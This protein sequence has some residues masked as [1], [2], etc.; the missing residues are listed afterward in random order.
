MI[1]TTHT[2][3]DLGHSRDIEM[4]RERSDS[5][6]KR[7]NFYPDSNSIAKAGLLEID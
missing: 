7:T 6:K 4:L 5:L 1:N 3:F 2:K